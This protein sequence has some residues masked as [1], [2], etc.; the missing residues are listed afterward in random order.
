MQTRAE[1]V[2]AAN[3]LQL[4]DT[5]PLPQEMARRMEMTHWTEGTL[6]RKST[7]RGAI[8]VLEFD[9]ELKGADA[10]AVDRV[11]FSDQVRGAVREAMPGAT[12]MTREN[13]LQL[14][15]AFGKKLEDSVGDCEVET[16]KLL[17]ADYV[18]S[19]RLTRVGMRCKLTLRVHETASGSLIGSA[20]ASGKTVDKLDDYTGR[21]AARP[22]RTAAPLI[23]DIDRGAEGLAG[24]LR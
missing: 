22:A 16:G 4:A 3:K 23:F 15:K 20:T 10:K 13:T 19:G 11:Y 9:D 17:Q 21:A 8:A 7:V 6:E 18:V 12:V 5:E 2:A 14:L 24:Q 1:R